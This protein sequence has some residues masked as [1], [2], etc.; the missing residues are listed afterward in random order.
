MDI[1]RKTRLIKTYRFCFKLFFSQSNTITRYNPFIQTDL[2]KCGPVVQ[3][4][5]EATQGNLLLIMFHQSELPSRNTR[6][7]SLKGMYHTLVWKCSLMSS[8]RQGT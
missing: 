5:L 7:R 6:V 3:Q 4:Q 1:S 8:D 2:H